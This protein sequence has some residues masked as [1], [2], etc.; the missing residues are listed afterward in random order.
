MGSRRMHAAHVLHEHAALR[1]C[2]S[3][4]E[5]AI[6]GLDEQVRGADAGRGAVALHRVAGRTRR[7]AAP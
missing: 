6:A 4:F 7:R 1:L 3:L 5:R 2:R